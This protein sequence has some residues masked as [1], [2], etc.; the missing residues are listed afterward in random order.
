MTK[1]NIKK[2]K[3]NSI[4]I[5]IE[6]ML[7]DLLAICLLYLTFIDFFQNLESGRLLL[8][9]MD[10]IIHFLFLPYFIIGI[11]Y[12]INSMILT[13]HVS[14]INSPRA[15]LKCMRFFHIPIWAA[16]KGSVYLLAYSKTLADTDG[17]KI[18]KVY[19]DIFYKYSMD[20]M[21]KIMHTYNM[22]DYF[23]WAGD[24]E[25][26]FLYTDEMKRYKKEFDGQIPQDYIHCIDLT[27]HIIACYDAFIQKKSSDEI[28][29]A[30]SEYKNLLCRYRNSKHWFFDHEN[31]YG[32][33]NV[34]IF[35]ALLAWKKGDPGKAYEQFLKVQTDPMY[36][37]NAIRRQCVEKWIDQLK[38]A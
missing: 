15:V 25:K 31:T 26:Y 18:E 23:F 19:N 9:I 10:G 38:N 7:I 4:L 33:I 22:A 8:N 3:K 20:S 36:E 21:T 37:H 24:S 14:R 34:E 16:S 30:I 13:I 32:A 28:E 6:I 29:E 2:L 11:F 12:S 27:E 5:Y 1:M 17:K 35:E